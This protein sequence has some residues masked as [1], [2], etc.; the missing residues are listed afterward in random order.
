MKKSSILT[1]VF[2]LLFSAT[3]GAVTQ[4]LKCVLFQN[5]GL[6][7]LIG[8]EVGYQIPADNSSTSWVK[9]IDKTTSSKSKAMKNSIRFEEKKITYINKAGVKM[10]YIGE[11]EKNLSHIKGVNENVRT[12][13]IPHPNAS[14]K[15]EDDYVATFQIFKKGIVLT[16]KDGG[17]P[18]IFT[19][20]A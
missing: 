14:P 10:E 11:T 13:K 18:M 16:F 4:N 3:S 20:K 6:F 15:D 9:V 17:N 12:W 19:L 8:D 7:S 5:P 2:G 1:L